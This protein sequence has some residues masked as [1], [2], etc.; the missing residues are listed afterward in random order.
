MSVIET[1]TPLPTPP[2]GVHII[3]SEHVFNPHSGHYEPR[4]KNVPMTAGLAVTNAA[5][6]LILGLVVANPA[7]IYHM[8]FSNNTAGIITYTLTEPGGMTY[9]V[10]VPANNSI[11]IVGTPDAPLFRSTGAGN[12]IVVGSALASGNITIAYV[13]K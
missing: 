3:T 10:T 13:I 7:W 5:Q 11:V 12:L 8:V 9:I 1:Q 4:V 6:P 2:T